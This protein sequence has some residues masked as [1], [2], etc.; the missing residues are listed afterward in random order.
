M[1]EL[2]I[3]FLYQPFFNILVL[4]Y[5]LIGKTP[6]GYDMGWAVIALTILVRIILL[7]LTI[8]GHR[9]ESERREIQEKVAL[10]K[11]QLTHDPVARKKAVKKV[12]RAK[13][14]IVISEFA[15]FLIQMVIALTLWRIFSAGL[16]G[17]D[18]HL[19]YDWVPDVAQPYQL[20]FLGRFDLTHP[21]LILNLTQAFLIFIIETISVLSTPHD[22]SSKEVV[23]VQLILPVVSFMFFAFMPAGKK[24]F[25]ITTLTFSLGV[26]FTRLAVR[27]WKKLFPAPAPESETSKSEASENADADLAESA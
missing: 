19:L 4:F 11:S 23:R 5:W 14:R 20:T 6:L 9:T 26:M 16:V 17:Q 25:V 1:L 27:W 21:D 22:V 24:L 2:F 8:A 15:T 10:V 12:M 3:T 13:P 18:I 7:P